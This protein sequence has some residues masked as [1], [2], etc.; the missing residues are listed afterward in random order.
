[1][2]VPTG[3]RAT[4]WWLLALGLLIVSV[5]GYSQFMSFSLRGQGTDSAADRSAPRHVVCFGFVDLEHG[6]TKLDPTQPGRVAEVLVREGESVPAGAVLLRMVDDVPRARADQARIGMETAQRDLEYARSTLPKKHELELQMQTDGVRQ[7]KG[8]VSAKKLAYEHKREISATKAIVSPTDVALAK[9]EW[10]AA[11]L[12]VQQEENKLK[13]LQMQDPNEEIRRLEALV[14][15]RT[16][17]HKQALAD[18]ADYTIR[19]PKAGTVLRITCGPGDPFGPT[20]RQH[21][22]EFAGDGPRLVRAEVEQAFASQVKPGQ[23]VTIEDGTNTGGK[24]TGRVERIGDYFTHKRSIVQEPD[25]FND[26]KTLEC[27]IALDPGQPPLK[28][29]QRV[30]VTIQTPGR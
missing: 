22:I 26:V 25:Q 24:W 29:N 19:A 7:A 1:M 9:E 3:K 11:Q 21:A 2:T 8:L 15:E 12:Q 13:L 20:S 16:A 14:G 6:I 23:T 5:A 17:L 18:L 30:L 4:R 27:I 28:I 10:D